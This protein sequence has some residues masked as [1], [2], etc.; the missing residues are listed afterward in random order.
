M[1]KKSFSEYGKYSEAP[2]NQK[3][4]ER[5]LKDIEEIDNY[6]CPHNIKKE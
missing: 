1:L 2:K 4:L 6:E 3:L 5:I